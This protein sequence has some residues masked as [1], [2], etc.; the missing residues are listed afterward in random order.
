MFCAV[1]VYMLPFCVVVFYVL[2]YYVCALML[3][4]YAALMFHLDLIR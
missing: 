1:T 3:W 4:Y 2:G